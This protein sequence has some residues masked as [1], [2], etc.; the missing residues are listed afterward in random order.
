MPWQTTRPEIQESA[1]AK[2]TSLK[3]ETPSAASPMLTFL[4]TS[5]MIR[6]HILC[7]YLFAIKTSISV[8]I[9]KLVALYQV[10]ARQ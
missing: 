7:Q 2:C 4:T 6:E 3:I 1:F 10:H 9:Y 5:K 8:S